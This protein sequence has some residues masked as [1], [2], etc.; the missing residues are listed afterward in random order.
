MD[1]KEL[2]VSDGMGGFIYVNK[3]IDDENFINIK[4]DLEHEDDYGHMYYKTMQLSL[5]K[6][7]V[8][9]LIDHLIKLL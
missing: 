7:D 8:K 5:Y 4:M 6:D 1:N 9:E 3:D 2:L